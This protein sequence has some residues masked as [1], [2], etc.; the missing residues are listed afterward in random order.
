MIRRGSYNSIMLY[1]QGV[2]CF[3]WGNTEIT[4]YFDF[5]I[6]FFGSFDPGYDVVRAPLWKFWGF[7]HCEASLWLC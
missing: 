2:L 1:I 4:N 7:R 5:I 3:K 6:I